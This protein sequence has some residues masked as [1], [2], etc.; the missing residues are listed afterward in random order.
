VLKASQKE[1]MPSLLAPAVGVMVQPPSTVPV[2]S[3]ST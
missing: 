1:S 3:L 2:P